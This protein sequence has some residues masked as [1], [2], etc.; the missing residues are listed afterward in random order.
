MS[1]DTEEF[2]RNQPQTRLDTDFCKDF[3]HR[4]ADSAY[5]VIVDS[6]GLATF[7]ALKRSL[8]RSPMDKILWDGILH[9]RMQV[10]AE[11]GIGPRTLKV[12][13]LG[14]NL[15]QSCTLSDFSHLR[16]ATGGIAGS[17]PLPTENTIRRMIAEDSEPWFTWPAQEPFRL[18][19]RY[20][21]FDPRLE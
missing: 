10:S 17:T 11:A 18:E 5:V 4:L 9:E 16:D 13:D 15:I 6:F 2:L 12:R 8:F 21:A 14:W 20:S 7:T 19:S 1:I 3:K